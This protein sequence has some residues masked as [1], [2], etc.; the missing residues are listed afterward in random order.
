MKVLVCGGRDYR[1]RNELFRFMDDLHET[2]PIT[3]IIEGGAWG[4]DRLARFWAINRNIPVQTFNAEWDRYGRDAG[5]I[6]NWQMLEEGKPDLVVAF[7]G[8]G[9]TGHMIRIS[10]RKGFNVVEAE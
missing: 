2:S 3:L 6:R 1:D 10:R 9:G 8:G 4:A 5:P 7:P